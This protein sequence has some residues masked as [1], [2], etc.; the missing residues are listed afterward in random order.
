M[1]LNFI[2]ID[3]NDRLNTTSPVKPKAQQ[4]TQTPNYLTV[5]SIHV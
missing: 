1:P 5:Y 4:C 2:Y 3:H